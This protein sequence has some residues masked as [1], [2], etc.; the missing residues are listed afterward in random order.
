MVF[1]CEGVNVPASRF[2]VHPIVERLERRGIQCRIVHGYGAFDTKIK[3]LSLQRLYR[4][5]CRLVRAFRTATLYDADLVFVQRLALP[6]F[7]APEYI[8]AWRGIPLV[9]D[10]DDAIDLGGNGQTSRLRANALRNVFKVSTLVVAGNS[11]LAEKARPFARTEVIPTCIDTEKYQPTSKKMGMEDNPVVGWMG[12]SSNYKYLRLLIPVFD[13]LRQEGLKFKVHVVSDSCDQQ[14][15]DA[16]GATFSFWSANEELSQLQCFDIGVMPLD[17]SDQSK[18]KCAF[19]LI[20]YMAVGIPVVGSDIGFNKDVVKHSI[21]GFLASNNSEWVSAIRKLLVDVGLRQ[22]IG[23]AARDRAVSNFS[24]DNAF[25]RY[26][27]C[28]EQIFRK[29][30]LGGLS[31]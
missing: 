17:D 24:V 14:L 2:R 7:S 1:L 22:H 15:M 10:F 11:W 12:T 18:G 13:Q 9:F 30:H 5:L 16:L 29:S 19:K 3:I 23:A 25:S 6:W 21:T 26:Y 28:F 8:L 27:D 31:R 4:L 20:Q